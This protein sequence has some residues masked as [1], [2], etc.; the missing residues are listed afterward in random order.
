[1]RRTSAHKEHNRTFQRGTQQNI[2]YLPGR[3]KASAT[4]RW[5]RQHS[6]DHHSVS[7][8]QSCACLL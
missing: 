4:A 6:A 2:A 3:R 8:S 1:V 5:W 7:D